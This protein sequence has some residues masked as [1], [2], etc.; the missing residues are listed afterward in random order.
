MVRP[1]RG[2]AA[3]SGI[4]LIADQQSAGSDGANLAKNGSRNRLTYGSGAQSG[5]GG[6]V[7][8]ILS[9]CATAALRP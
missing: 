8:Q 2:N 3:V 5:D 1:S 9:R 4:K 7:A 6:V